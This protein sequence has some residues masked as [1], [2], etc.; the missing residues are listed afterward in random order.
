AARAAPAVERL[1]GLRGGRVTDGLHQ[2]GPQGPELQLVEQRA[3]A[4]TIE[5]TGDELGRFDVELD[6]APQ[7]RHLAVQQ[8]ALTELREIL[9]LSR[10]KLV[11]VVE[12]AFERLVGRHELRGRL[13]ADAG[14]AGQL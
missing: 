5:R 13:L 12:D 10:R 14:N 3:R 1:L 6:V 2:A 7:Q 11:E 8:D 9:T 4:F